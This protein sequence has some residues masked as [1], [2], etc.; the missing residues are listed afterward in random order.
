MLGRPASRCL[1]STHGLAPPVLKK[2]AAN[3]AYAFLRWYTTVYLSGSSILVIRFQP[4]RP[5][6]LLAGL[7]TTLVENTTSSAVNGTPSDHFTP[8]RRW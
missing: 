5:T 2:V 6:S 7:S 8:L 1:G 4:S 3:G